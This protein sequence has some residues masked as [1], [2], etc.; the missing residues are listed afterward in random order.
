MKKEYP[1][2]DVLKFSF[3]IIVVAVHVFAEYSDLVFINKP[4]YVLTQIG[5]A[6]YFTASG[7]FVFSKYKKTMDHSVFLKQAIRLLILYLIYNVIYFFV[8]VIMPSIVASADFLIQSKKFI[9]DMFIGG[10]SVMWFIWSLIVI[11]FLLFFI[12]WKKCNLNRLLVISVSAGFVLYLSCY[13]LFDFYGPHYL[14]TSFVD[15]VKNHWSYFGLLRLIGQGMFFVP[16]G[17]L[18]SQ[19]QINRKRQILITFIIC[20]FFFICEYLIT[21]LIFKRGICFGLIMPVLITS[22]F[23]F[24]LS[25]DGL[26]KNK[27]YVMLRNMSTAIYLIHTPIMNVMHQLFKRG[28]LPILNGFLPFVTILMLSFAYFFIVNFAK[29]YKFLHWMK[30]LY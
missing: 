7:F 4:L 11:N 25:Y 13:I 2:I 24:I 26:S 5:M 1:L 18:I 3:A 6:F 19:I 27:K 20:T 29:K 16:L 21:F 28:I 12:T 30:Y 10:T 15:N 17:G 23:F 14:P 22:G 9:R 8:E